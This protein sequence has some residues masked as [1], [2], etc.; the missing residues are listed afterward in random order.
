MSAEKGSFLEG[1]GAIEMRALYAG[2][3][4]IRTESP[5]LVSAQL[6]IHVTGE[7]RNTGNPQ[8]GDFSVK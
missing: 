7:E 8:D 4:V 6:C 5:G 3:T 1:M 2:D